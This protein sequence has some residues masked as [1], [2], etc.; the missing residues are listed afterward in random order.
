MP[1]YY[2]VAVPQAAKD[3]NAG[4]P[5]GSGG[6]GETFGTNAGLPSTSDHSSTNGGTNV[7][8][9]NGASQDDGGCQV[10]LG[11]GSSGGAGLLAVL[12]MLGL[13]RKRRAKAA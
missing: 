4:G 6:S 11:H 1:P 10:A 3:G 2:D 9:A 13:V 8:A 7:R 12:G 5:T